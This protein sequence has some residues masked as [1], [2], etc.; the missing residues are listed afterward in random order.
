MLTAMA[1]TLISGI[2]VAQPARPPPGLA[3]PNDRIVWLNTSSHVYHYQGDHNYG[4]TQQGKFVCEK[5]AV[6]EHDHPAAK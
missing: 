2:A 5:M 3:C 6:S 4:A 1:F